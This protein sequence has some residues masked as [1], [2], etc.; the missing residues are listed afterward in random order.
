MTSEPPAEPAVPGSAGASEWLPHTGASSKAPAKEP[1]AS[2]APA[3]RPA[4]RSPSADEAWLPPELSADP[5][6]TRPAP[7]ARAR[8][9]PRNAAARAAAPGARA[10]GRQ[11]PVEGAS[12]AIG[13]RSEHGAARPPLRGPLTAAAIALG[14]IIA[15]TAGALI[16]T[17]RAGK[18]STPQAQRTGRVTTSSTPSDATRSAAAGPPGATRKKRGAPA[19]APHGLATPFVVHGSRF[20]VFVVAGKPWTRA[21]ATISVPGGK[22]IVFVEV[23]A[24]RLAPPAVDLQ[25]LRFRV[26][27]DGLT[28]PP[29]A[30][31]G[32]GGRA[33]GAAQTPT[34][35]QLVVNHLAFEVTG[36]LSSLRLKFEP[37]NAGGTPVTVALAG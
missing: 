13:G 14:A 4:G 8:L 22:R 31:V 27:D 25:A 12:A 1:P 32:T 33:L 23:L 35:N 19:G 34:L 3:A 26:V 18:A 16:L 10:L 5:G 37:T 29:L 24:R 6:S 36:P 28:V 20:A 17:H 21:A 7:D 15:A 11:G 9:V 30:G 2:R